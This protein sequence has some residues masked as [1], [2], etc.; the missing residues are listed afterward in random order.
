MLT[1]CW[2]AKGGNGTT[3]VSCALALCRAIRGESALLI[4][5]AGDVPSVLGVAEP[6]S[7]G[8]HDWVASASATLAAVDALAVSAR[9]GLRFVHAGAA[10]PRPGD[11][12]WNQLGSAFA[13]PP[14]HVIVDAGSR[15]GDVPH[16]LLQAAQHR[17]LVIRPCYLALRRAAANDLTPTG[18]IVV[19]EPGRVL[20]ADDVALATHTPVVAEISL[21]PAVARAVDAGLLGSRL[22]RTLES[23]LRGLS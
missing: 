7:P 19:H 4:D 20:R 8:I 16:G 21:D 13:A 22:P 9:D 6:T 17:L 14:E 11:A 15:V 12:R 23:A 1:V 10:P 3:V 2:A 5:L 18:V